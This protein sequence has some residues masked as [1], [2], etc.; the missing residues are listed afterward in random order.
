[1]LGDGRVPGRTVD[2][3]DDVADRVDG[4][5]QGAQPADQLGVAGLGGVVPSVP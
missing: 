3:S 1:M 2:G 4:H 5:V